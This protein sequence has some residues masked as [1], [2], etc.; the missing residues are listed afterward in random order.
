MWKKMVRL[1]N[2]W[3]ERGRRTGNKGRKA[4]ER[5]NSR[6]RSDTK[7]KNKERKKKEHFS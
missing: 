3:I 5:K 2:Y 1:Q 6:E 4:I 7:Y